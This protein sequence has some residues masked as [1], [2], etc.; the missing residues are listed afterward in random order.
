MSLNTRSAGVLPRSPSASRPLP[1]SPTT[2][3]GSAPAQS[4]SSS[5]NLRRAGAS[6]STTNILSG[7]SDM[8]ILGV[9]R[10]AVRHPDVHFVAVLAGAAF[11]ARLRVEVQ[12]QTLPDVVHRHL[13]PGMVAA[14]KAVRIAQ[15]GVNF[16][17]AQENVN[18][19]DPRRARRLDA[20][21]HRVL[22]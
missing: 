1:A 16:P 3:S 15:D 17:A 9:R 2:I 13:V 11:E 18:R 20:V 6:S 14:G 4:S 12:R 22:Q 8:R 19:D 7:V 5:R 10:S 21:I